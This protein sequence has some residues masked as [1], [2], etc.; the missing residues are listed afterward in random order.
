MAMVEHLRGNA[1]QRPSAARQVSGAA[2]GT[3]SDRPAQALIG[4]LLVLLLY[5]AFAHGAVGSNIEVRIQVAIALLAAVA[6][7]AWLWSSGLR[8]SA[9][10]VAFAG[11]GLL[12]AFAAWSGL[13]LLWSVAPDRTW[14]EFNRD[15]TYVI[16]LVLAIMAGASHPRSVEMVGKGFLAVALV[17]TG[18]ALGQKVAPGIHIGSVL[19]F[20]QTAVV[21]RLQAPLEYWN[22]LAL[23][24]TLGVPIALALAVDRS[25]REHWR[26]GA[27]IAVQLMLLVIGLTY[28]RGGFLAL[29]LALIL[30]IALGGVRLRSLMWL[31]LACVA[32]VPPLL[33]ALTDHSLTNSGVPLGTRESAAGKLAAVLVVSVLA[34]YFGGRWLLRR[35]A[36]TRLSPERARGVGRLLV[37]AAGVVLVCAVL[38]VAASSR[39]LNGSV[40]HAW[41]SFTTARSANVYD[42]NHLLSSDSGNRWVWWK[43]AGGAFSDRPLAGWGAGSFPVV[44]L[45]YRRDTLSVRQPHSVPFQFL[46]EVGLVGTMLGIGGYGLLFAAGVRTTRRRPPGTER[47]IAAALIAGGVAYAAHALYDWDWDIPGVTLPAIVFLGVVAGA[48]GY[49]TPRPRMRSPGF[50]LRSIAIAVL[51]FSLCTFALS[52]LLPELAGSKASS[53]LVAASSSSPARL[54]SALATADVATRI[55]PVSDEGLKAAATIATHRGQLATARGYLLDAIRRDPNDAG[56]WEQLAGVEIQLG[57]RRGLIRAVNRALALDPRGKL[58]RALGRDAYALI[59]PTSPPPTVTQ[60]PLPAA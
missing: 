9:S 15:L 39:G 19:D 6:G 57:D 36:K 20:N 42:P 28:S 22:A 12:A 55:D 32:A 11:A 8:L 21:P 1:G 2:T 18:Y 10:P 3:R 52:A 16:V 54:Q 35:E 44:H 29:A 25:G 24:I 59:A 43:E 13:S 34:L 41:H 14:I 4:A 38:V 23:F 30:S 51:T 33:V 48:R 53:A 47:M 60:T 7:A 56:A 5:A 31:A 27:L 45:L 46:A 50:G 40:S 58:A 17:V 49:S 26:L 37:L